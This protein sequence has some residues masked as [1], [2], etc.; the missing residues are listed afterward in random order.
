MKKNIIRLENV[1]KTYK[2]GDLE[3]NAL[4]GVNL[5]VKEGEFLSV[6]VCVPVCVPP[7]AARGATVNLRCGC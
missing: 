1:W 5:E 7:S 4:Q 2:M 3:V 6:M